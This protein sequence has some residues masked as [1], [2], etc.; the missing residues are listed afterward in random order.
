[1][2]RGLYRAARAATGAAVLRR[3]RRA[4]AAHRPAA[5]ASTT[6]ATRRCPRRR[7]RWPG[8]AWRPWLLPL[9]TTGHWP[10]REL[11]RRPA[12]QAISL[13]GP[14]CLRRLPVLGQRVSRPGNWDGCPDDVLLAQRRNRPAGERR[15]LHIDSVIPHFRSPHY[16][17]VDGAPLPLV[18]RA[19]LLSDARGPWRLAWLPRRRDAGSP[20]PDDLRG[21]DARASATR[22]ISAS[23]PQVDVPRRIGWPERPP[24]AT[25]PG[26]TRSSTDTGPATQWPGGV[27]PA[28]S[29]AGAMAYQPLPRHHAGLGQHAPP[30]PAA[31]L[32]VD[33]TPERREEFRLRRPAAQGPRRAYSRRRPPAVRGQRRRWNEWGGRRASRARPTARSAPRIPT[34]PGAAVQAPGAVEPA[35]ASAA[36][37][38]AAA[39]APRR[40][41]GPELTDGAQTCQPQA[42]SMN[43]TN[44]MNPAPSLPPPAELMARVDR[45]IHPERGLSPGPL[46]RRPRAGCVLLLRPSAALR[47]DQTASC[48][49]T[50]APA[51]RRTARSSTTAATPCRMAQAHCRCCIRRP[52]SL[53]PD[54]DAEATGFCAGRLRL[55]AAV[56][57]RSADRPAAAGRVG[58]HGAG[59]IRRCHPM[60]RRPTH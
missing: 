56:D 26:L 37:P 47:G 15:R 52:A 12:G 49:G 31:K 25:V 57:A 44:T 59:C 43:A 3:A 34:P 4:T 9:T 7:R 22:H 13:P 30:R 50:S 36:P 10:G 28:G 40:A 6:C 19:P 29:V 17:T 32:F 14:A 45:S 41:A 58:R 48:A 23:T 35:P 2:G 39:P 53:P 18:Y 1:M 20:A 21:G 51:R 11:P 16:I 55:R 54:L 46:R 24:P 60:P 42:R 33:A 8:R 38:Q 27:A 5:P